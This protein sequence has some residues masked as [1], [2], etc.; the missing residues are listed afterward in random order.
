MF[1]VPALPRMAPCDSTYLDSTRVCLDRESW[2]S[3]NADSE[4]AERSEGH[5]TKGSHTHDAKDQ[6][7]GSTRDSNNLQHMS[8]GAAHAAQIRGSMD[9]HSDRARS[10]R[11]S[12]KQMTKEMHDFLAE[13]R[14][15]AEFGNKHDRPSYPR[16]S[17]QDVRQ[18]LH[19]RPTSGSRP[20]S[21]NSSE[22]AQFA[23]RSASHALP[24]EA[25][26][27][28]SHTHQRATNAQ[29]DSSYDLPD[30][31]VRPH[32]AGLS[33]RQ[34][35][36]QT[37]PYSFPGLSENGSGG[38][39]GH[40]TPSDESLHWLVG[41]KEAK[42]TQRPSWN[43]SPRTQNHLQSQQV[44]R[45]SPHS[46]SFPKHATPLPPAA[47]SFR[48]GSAST[49]FWMNPSTRSRHPN[50]A[51]R[52]L[53]TQPFSLDT[54][55]ALLYEPHYP[56]PAPQPPP[57]HVTHPIS[58]R[59]S[60]QDELTEQIDMRLLSLEKKPIPGLPLDQESVKSQYSNP[61]S[62]RSSYDYKI[63][64]GKEPNSGASSLRKDYEADTEEDSGPKP[65][66]RPSSKSASSTRA[67][68]RQYPRLKSLQQASLTTL[69]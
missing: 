36:L 34:R 41:V 42:N 12:T 23:G 27:S 6:G 2:S 64:A 10:V 51:A 4:V 54:H 57:L 25:W 3:S 49:D 13:Q 35:A 47:H 7:S 66:S 59:S 40:T 14:A 32:T 60:R 39:Y 26:T 28:R 29:F 20:S 65:S 56:Q 38:A 22:R 67:R 50:L 43:G 46:W 30:L 15:A 52:S 8:N 17:S 53:Q 69:D 55:T 68:A 1:A 11:L 21:S 62:Y 31:P 5:G 19:L 16:L 33:K 24:D 63:L 45:D 9:S 61:R 48:D 44:H 58:M 37:A 18:G